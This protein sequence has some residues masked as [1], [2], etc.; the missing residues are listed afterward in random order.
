[1]MRQRA[2]QF[3]MGD[4]DEQSARM[5][6]AMTRMQQMPVEEA[7][8]EGDIPQEEVIEEV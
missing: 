7:P 8:V 5:A 3:L 4:P 1:M 2:Q 6:D